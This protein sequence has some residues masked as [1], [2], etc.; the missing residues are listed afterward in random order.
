[1]TDLFYGL[2]GLVGFAHPIHP[3]LITMVV[4]PV[5]AS[6]LFIAIAFFLKKPDFYRTGRQ[7]TVVAF[8]FWFP[9]VAVGI[10]DWI[11]FYGGSTNMAEI[12]IKLVLAGILFL[13]LL[14]NMLLFKKGK[15]Q[16]LIPLV[17][18]LLSTANVSAL[19][20]YGGDIV[21]GGTPKA[22]E[23]PKAPAG[24]ATVNAEGYKEL[25]QE[26]YTL[27]WKIHDGVIDVK[28]SYATD[29]WVGFGI[30]KTG[31]ME[32]SHIILGF[33]FDGTA[34]VADHFGYATSKHGPQDKV[35]GKDSLTAR[36][37]TLVDGVTTITFSMPTNTGNPK[38]PVLVEGESYKVI[39]AN[40]GEGAI[41]LESYHGRSGRIILD[42]T[43]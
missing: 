32:G 23:A 15:E 26:G 27:G 43:L 14:G 11:H 13:L 38:D 17:L 6:F 1:M 8:I 5:I 7:L 25:V 40:G 4:G 19:G 22:N 9:T 36:G 31:T 24:Q 39:L 28:V 12:N 33:V 3:V 42:V 18:M 34:T 10:I 21:F 20:Y 29:G 35:G 16:P 30:G 37:G 41:D 2:L